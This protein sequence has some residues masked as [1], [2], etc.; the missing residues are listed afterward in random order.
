VL[1]GMITSLTIGL[2]VAYSIHISERYNIELDRQDDA[3]EAMRVSLTGTGGALLGSAATTVGGFGVLVF[4]I[5]PPLQQ[6][7]IITGMTIIYAFVA[8]VVVLPS[9]LVVWTRYIG[10]AE[11]L[12]ASSDDS[13][14]ATPHADE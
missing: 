8:S 9:L 5:M 13:P 2:G 4:A 3:W 1:T 6:F 10:P 14:T 7:G 12:D 11:A